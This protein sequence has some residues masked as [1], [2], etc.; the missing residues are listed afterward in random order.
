MKEPDS[1]SSIEPLKYKK[2]F[3]NFVTEKI[4]KEGQESFAIQFSEK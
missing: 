1:M 4:L 2:R 3:L